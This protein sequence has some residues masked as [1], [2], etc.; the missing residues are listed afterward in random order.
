MVA[1][2]T[3]NAPAID[4]ADPAAQGVV[5]LR[6]YILHP[7]QR[8]ILIDLFERELIEPQEVVGMAVLGQFIDIDEPDSLVWLRGFADMKTRRRGLT[9][10]YEGPVWRAHREAANATMIDSDN[11]FLLEAANGGARLNLGGQRP[12]LHAAALDRGG[13]VIGIHYVLAGSKAPPRDAFEAHAVPMLTASKGSLL[14]YFSSHDAVNDYPALP[15]RGESVLV[16][17]LVFPRAADLEQDWNEIRQMHRAVHEKTI[18]DGRSELLRLIPTRR[19]LV[20]GTTNPCSAAISLS[21]AA[22]ERSEDQ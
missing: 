5:E 18:G 13:I 21:Q 2:L 4:P 9:A 22:A 8:D 14:A 6:R 3:A 19:S 11:V 17:L 7:N 16:W 15:V 10:F 20:A 12:E 1:S